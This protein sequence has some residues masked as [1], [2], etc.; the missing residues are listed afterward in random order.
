MNTV[1][2]TLTYTHTNPQ[3]QTLRLKING[4]S[5]ITE[6]TSE[7]KYAFHVRRARNDS[8]LTIF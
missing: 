1:S 8:N 2:H 5:V 6:R 7:R 3:I 4:E